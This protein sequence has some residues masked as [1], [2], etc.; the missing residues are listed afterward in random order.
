MVKTW[1]SGASKAALAHD[2]DHPAGFFNSN[3]R[4]LQSDAGQPLHIGQAH[5]QRAAPQNIPASY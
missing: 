1:M 3:M 4:S 2:I 5:E